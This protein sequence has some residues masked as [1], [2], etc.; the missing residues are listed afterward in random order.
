M[1]NTA[2][3]YRTIAN[4]VC[5]TEVVFGQSV[6]AS[7]LLATALYV[8]WCGTWCFYLL[9]VPSL[10][11]LLPYVG[12]IVSGQYLRNKLRRQLDRPW[13][14]AYFIGF[15]LASM[16]VSL[17]WFKDPMHDIG[18]LFGSH[19]RW[20]CQ[21]VNDDGSPAYFLRDRTVPLILFAPVLL[22]TA[23]HWLFERLTRARAQNQ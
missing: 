23:G 16:L 3:R 10:L 6:S 21:A 18:I 22:V 17:Q 11:M 2:N 5:A 12:T 8:G 7:I 14:H 15:A 13:A 1:K 19:G 20:G 9:S 4:V